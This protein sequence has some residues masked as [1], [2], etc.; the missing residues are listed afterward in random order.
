LACCMRPSVDEDGH[1]QSATGRHGR[2][3]GGSSSKKSGNIFGR[4]VGLVTGTAL[5]A[6]TTVAGAVTS[7]AGEAANMSMVRCNPHRWMRVVER[8]SRRQPSLASALFL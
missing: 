6:V 7:V 4:G 1:P 5:D 8:I 2:K 3:K